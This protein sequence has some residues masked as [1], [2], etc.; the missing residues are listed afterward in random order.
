MADTAVDKTSANGTT[1]SDTPP[2]TVLAKYLATQNIT[3]HKL[4]QL[5][6]VTPRAV[7]ALVEGEPAL[8]APKTM[9]AISD[10]TRL[11]IDALLRPDVDHWQRIPA[12]A[13]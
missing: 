3:P 10:Y 2:A 7:Y 4:A 8:V 6:K 9:I 11:S 12:A 5:C 1:N 13:R